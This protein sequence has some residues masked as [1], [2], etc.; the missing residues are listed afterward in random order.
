MPHIL[1]ASQDAAWWAAGTS[2]RPLLSRVPVSKD[3]DVSLEGCSRA[4]IR[5]GSALKCNR[6]E[7]S[8]TVPQDRRQ[9]RVCGGGDTGLRE[10]APVQPPACVPCVL[11]GDVAGGNAGA[12]AKRT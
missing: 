9:A 1:C 3:E 8:P 2:P 7:E 10:G 4:C 11:P 12:T 5:G 6:G